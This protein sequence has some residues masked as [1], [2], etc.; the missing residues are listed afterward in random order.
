VVSNNGDRCHRV[1]TRQENGAP[2]SLYD[3]C[4]KQAKKETLHE[5]SAFCALA[6]FQVRHPKVLF[7]HSKKELDAPIEL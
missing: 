3:T 1:E 7:K 5:W 4:Q 6:E 2:K